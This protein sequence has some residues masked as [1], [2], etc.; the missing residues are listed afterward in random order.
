MS[1]ANWAACQ[2]NNYCETYP[3]LQPAEP[4]HY[5]F[6]VRETYFLDQKYV[7][8]D[9]KPPNIFKKKKKNWHNLKINFDSILSSI[10]YTKYLLSQ[11]NLS[12][13][14]DPCLKQG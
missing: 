8:D 6:H 5:I 4:M 10:T 11:E 12:E 1:G 9:N 14:H 7:M 13:V 3:H 2:P